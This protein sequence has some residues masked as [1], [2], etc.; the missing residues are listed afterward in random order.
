MSP[1]T[2]AAR[3]RRAKVTS[4]VGAS[5]EVRLSPRTGLPVSPYNRVGK[6]KAPAKVKTKVKAKTKAVVKT[7]RTRKARTKQADPNLLSNFLSPTGSTVGGSVGA[8][9][10]SPYDPRRS[11]ILSLAQALLLTAIQGAPGVVPAGDE[12]REFVRQ[13]RILISEVD[14]PTTRT[15]RGGNGQQAQSQ[16]QPQHQHQPSLDPNAFTGP[17]VVDAEDDE[18][19]LS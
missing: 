2:R 6:A 1:R 18:L 11:E 16:S 15:S 7:A 9:M 3:T 8:G 4:S 19:S 17:S 5:S 10:N 13:A 14:Q 12:I